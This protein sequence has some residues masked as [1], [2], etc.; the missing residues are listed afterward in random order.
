MWRDMV[1][2]LCIAADWRT[3]G[4]RHS[5]CRI[6]VP[7]HALLACNVSLVT[8]GTILCG[9]VMCFECMI[10]SFS[11]AISPDSPSCARGVRGQAYGGTT[12]IR[13]S[14]RCFMLRFEWM[15]GSR[16]V[17]MSL[18]ESWLCLIGR[19]GSVE[20]VRSRDLERVVS[21]AFLVVRLPHGQGIPEAHMGKWETV[22]SS[23]M[24][25]A[26]QSCRPLLRCPCGARRTVD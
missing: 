16:C 24:E 11:S 4:H 8:T 7:L 1:L 17:F 15:L 25:N 21:C 19:F 2:V 13:T 12:R 26:C 22:F 9:W 14:G 20:T 6:T 3:V 5:R 18:C 23:G 10:V